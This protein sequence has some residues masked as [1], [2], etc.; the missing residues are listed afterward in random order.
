MK[1]MREGPQQLCVLERTSQ[2]KVQKKIK[3]VW[4]AV[5]I[6]FEFELFWKEKGENHPD[7]YF[8]KT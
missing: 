6:L 3:L 8:L 4:P 1:D 2:S 5:Q 7:V